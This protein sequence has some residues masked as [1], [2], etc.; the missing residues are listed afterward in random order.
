MSHLNHLNLRLQGKNHTVADMYEAI[1]AFQSKLHLLERDIHGRKL[2]FPRLREHCEKNKMQEDPAM[3]DFVSRL[4][5]NI[6]ERFE[7]APKLSADI[8]LFVRQPFSVPA[9]GQWTA[10]AK[11]LVP[12]I[13]EAALQMEILE[14]GTSDLLKAQHKDALKGCLIP[15]RSL[16]SLIES[17]PERRYPK[18]GC[19][20]QKWALCKDLFLKSQERM[21]NQENHEENQAG[22][23]LHKKKPPRVP[24]GF[25]LDPHKAH[26]NHLNNHNNHS[27]HHQHSDQENNNPRL[28][29]HTYG[30]KKNKNSLQ[31]KHRPG[32]RYLVKTRTKRMRLKWGSRRKCDS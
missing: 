23:P 27:N 17:P 20:R 11:K 15:S 28:A 31:K 5:E 9:D 10:E 7:S 2:H 32:H 22:P 13:D 1:E 8:L 6:K 19:F 24:N 25:S 30:K 3:K 29:L 18:H 16:L 4:A 14:M 21:E 12:S 26:N